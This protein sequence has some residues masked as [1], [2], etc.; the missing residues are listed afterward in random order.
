MKV[1]IVGNGVAG[2][3][4]AQ[5]LYF[6]N[7]EI[8]IEIFTQERYPYYTRIKL[9]EVISDKVQAYDLIVFEDDW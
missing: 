1:V 2:V 9:P 6:L 4:T 5:N 8:D 7:K 3:F